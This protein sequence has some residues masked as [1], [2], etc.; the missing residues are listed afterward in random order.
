MDKVPEIFALAGADGLVRSSEVPVRRLLLERG[1]IH[2]EFTSW[3]R[4]QST[5]NW[6]TNPD[7]QAKFT[8]GERHVPKAAPGGGGAAGAN[9]TAHLAF[10]GCRGCD[11]EAVAKNQAMANAIGPARFAFQHRQW[12]QLARDIAPLDTSPLLHLYSENLTTSL[13]VCNA[14]MARVYAFLGLPSMHDNCNISA[15]PV[16]WPCDIQNDPKCSM[17]KFSA[18]KLAE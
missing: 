6:G 8:S 7:A 5:G 16:E 4:A 12:F 9:A 17:E 13:A 2:A 3:K 10:R 15:I 14:T 11:P 18:E 1:D